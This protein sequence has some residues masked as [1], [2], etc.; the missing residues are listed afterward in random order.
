MGSSAKSIV[1][2]LAGLGATIVWSSPPVDATNSV[3]IVDSAGD[4][5]SATS[6]ALDTAGHPVVSYYDSTPGDLKL[7]HC[8]DANCAGGGDSI[9]TVDSAANVGQ[10]SSLA[11]DAVGNPVISYY[12]STNGDL[13]LAHCNDE[14]CAG[15]GDSIAPVE[16]STN[17]GQYSS[18]E[19]DAAGKP[20]IS[21]FDASNADLKLVHCDDVNCAGTNESIVTVDNGPFVGAYGSLEL[22]AAG[23]PVVSYHDS[24]NG[25]LKVV[26][27]NDANCLAG[28][29]SVVT[30]DSNGTVGLFTS[31]AL[32]AAGNPV[33]SYYS[34]SNADLKVVHCDDANCAGANES[35]VT[36]DSIGNVGL[37]SSLV[38]DSAGDPVIS[39]HD[40][41]NGE[42]QVVHCDDADCA[43]GDAIVTVDSRFGN[44]G[45][46]T[47][48]ALDASGNP[49]VSYR[50]LLNKDLKVAHC[51]TASCA[52]PLCAGATATI[53][54]TAGNDVIDGTAGADVIVA[55]D[56]DDTIEGLDGNDLICGGAGDDEVHAG[57]G[58]DRVFGDVGLDNL[59][60]QDGDDRLDGSPD[61]DR[62][63][64]GAGDDVLVGASGDDEFVGDDGADTADFSASPAGVSVDLVTQL[65]SGEG[66]DGLS[67]VEN[68]VG[69]S[70]GDGL[71]GDAGGN[72]I[73][74]GPGDDTINGA[75][76]DDEL[77]GGAGVDHL[78]GEEGND[79]LD[80]GDGAD[81]LL[82][83]E[84]NDLVVGGEGHDFM[85]GGDGDDVLA[86]SGGGDGIFGD[87]G[88]DTASFATSPAAVTADLAAGTATGD[89]SDALEAVE[90]LGGSSFDD[91]LT[92]DAGANMLDGAGGN[93]IV[94]GLAG[95]DVLAGSVG[96]DTV[97]GGGDDD[98]LVGGAGDD[99]IDGGDGSDRLSFT[100]SSAA[101]S[102]D[103]SALSATG[104]GTDVVRSVN[105]VV[106]SS[107][108]DRLTGDADANAIDGGGGRD[109][110]AGLAGDDALAGGAGVDTVTYAAS[111]GPLTVSLRSGTAV[112]DGA[113]QLSG[114]E[115][116]V[117]SAFDDVLSGDAAANVL[118]GGPGADTVSFAAAPAP[119][120]ASLFGGV[121]V[122]EGADRLVRF[123]D[124]VGSRFA[125][126][127][128]GD[129][130]RNSIQGGNGNDVLAGRGGN[131]W[132]DGGTGVDAADFA[133]ATKAVTASL[134][135][136]TAT[137]EG[138]DLLVGFETLRGSPFADTLMGNAGPN[139]LS[140]GAGDDRLAGLAGNDTLDGGSG[141][142]TANFAAATRA[143][144]ANLRTGSATGEGSDRL[145]RLENLLGSSF[146]DRLTGNARRNTLWGG[147]GNDTLTAGRGNDALNGGAQFDR[148]DG[149]AGIDTQHKCELTVHIP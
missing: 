74:G 17:V 36:V 43:D 67:G 91:V 73:D 7:V 39:Y 27:C 55:G 22:D 4:I 143:V 121:A 5:D 144:T 75:L 149:G 38:L 109:V 18:L 97:F 92:G 62:L 48:L 54:G 69:S 107:F 63:A 94:A 13:K 60:G 78:F 98:E 113:D 26:H 30:V 148:A 117:G 45:W 130:G 15:D 3:V 76:G 28:G 139:T 93:D 96:D 105:A 70:F 86:G 124:L 123:E 1:A 66:H 111:P 51:E 106:G 53:V 57:G 102:V 9:E 42:L 140:G 25:D 77:T 83:H 81:L 133:A 85:S 100:A 101:V 52:P 58:D 128:T 95:D 29:D 120:T 80:G 137:G 118:D 145:L 136:G 20:V 44:L 11:L 127:L 90:N 138:V 6:V 110:I 64:G 2:V 122:G 68:L 108:D 134:T 31:L 40:N 49:V 125:D 35:I 89:G 129:A 37:F 119:V 46:N 146:A 104:E 115:N 114:L 10:H 21:Y 132:L 141:A 34:S 87:G 71:A 24:T 59:D 33:I 61:D 79:G 23:N 56:G 116:V 47:S 112:G 84:G 16:G 142:D 50:D 14:K 135:S 65:A 19:L 72:T 131:D 41:S 82:A 147:N 12:D 126:A 103:L 8:D 32:D 99:V 88:V